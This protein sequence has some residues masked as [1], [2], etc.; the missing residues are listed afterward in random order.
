[1]PIYEDYNPGIAQVNAEHLFSVAMFDVMKERMTS[2]QV[3]DKA[4]ASQHVS[5]CRVRSRM[6]RPH[7]A[8]NAGPIAGY[9]RFSSRAFRSAQSSSILS[10][11]AKSRCLSTRYR[12][13]ANARRSW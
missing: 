7:C 13:P 8:V 10:S 3:I 1:M 9:R 12:D 6:I 4:F 2:D 5:A 11:Y